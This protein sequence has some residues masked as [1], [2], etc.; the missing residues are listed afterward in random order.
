VYP[1]VRDEVLAE[2][3]QRALESSRRG[4]QIV[5]SALGGDAP[6]MGAAELAFEGLLADPLGTLRKVSTSR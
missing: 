4:V 3:E 5:S 6:L 1:Y 2:V